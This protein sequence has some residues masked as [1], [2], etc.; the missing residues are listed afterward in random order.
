L[1]TEVLRE[2]AL[3]SACDRAPHVD[4]VDHDSETREKLSPRPVPTQGKN[5]AST[6]DQIPRARDAGGDGIDTICRE[7]E[8][9]DSSPTRDSDG[10]SANEDLHRAE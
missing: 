6:Q 9:G 10:R 5:E 7:G 1:L 2:T 8:N 4:K 3:K